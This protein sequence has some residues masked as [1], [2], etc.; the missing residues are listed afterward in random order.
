MKRK[1]SKL[2]FITTSAS[3]AEQAC[4]GGIDWIQLR[5]KNVSYSEYRDMALEVQKV[6][7]K[8]N[9]ALIINDRADLA[10]EIGADGVHVG[11]TD[12]LS[13][14]IKPLTEGGFIIGCTANTIE[15]FEH[16]SGKPVD[17]IGLGP[18]RFTET[19]Q[20]LS[21]VLGLEG[22][23]NLLAALKTIPPPI[24][25]IGGIIEKDVPDL[26]ATGLYG[27]AVSGAISNALNVTEAAKAFKKYFTNGNGSFA[28]IAEGLTDA[29][30]IINLFE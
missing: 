10:L 25:G 21:P 30:D 27:I 16:L 5:L 24:I 23:R 9:A 29:I 18:F 1:I 6:C 15:D 11:K 19:K 4:K 8:Y 12:P 2:Q 7:K 14:Y 28:D 26:L 13:D 20:N 17:Y 3:L 22:Y